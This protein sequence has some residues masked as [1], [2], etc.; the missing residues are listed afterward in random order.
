VCLAIF[1]GTGSPELLTAKDAKYSQ[2][3]RR[4]T[5]IQDWDRYQG[6]G[7]F[8]TSLKPL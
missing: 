1:C 6:L 5:Y 3:S 7:E 4:K 8:A 2:K